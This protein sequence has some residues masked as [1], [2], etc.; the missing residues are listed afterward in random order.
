MII[1]NKQ[2]SRFLVYYQTHM[3]FQ[4]FDFFMK[5]SIL[6]FSGIGLRTKYASEITKDFLNNQS[7]VEL[8][9]IKGKKRTNLFSFNIIGFGAPVYSFRGPWIVTRLLKKIGNQKENTFSFLYNWWNTR[10]K[11]KKHQIVKVTRR[12]LQEE[13]YYELVKILLDIIGCN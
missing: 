1:W 10:C 8:N 7:S 12:F 5:I 6:C 4:F 11:K 9:H 3:N 13:K 2:I